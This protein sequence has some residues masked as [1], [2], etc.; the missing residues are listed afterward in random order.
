MH[1]KVS[2]FHVNVTREP[3]TY[4]TCFRRDGSV[5]PVMYVCEPSVPP[6]EL[7]DNIDEMIDEA[8]AKIANSFVSRGQSAGLRRSAPQV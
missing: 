4:M 2:W 8:S 1:G 5:I 3:T 7:P 6:V